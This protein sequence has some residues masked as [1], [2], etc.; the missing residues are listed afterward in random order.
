M[1]AGEA[2]RAKENS[3]GYGFSGA[4]QSTVEGTGPETK[5]LAAALKW[6]RVYCPEQHDLAIWEALDDDSKKTLV[7]LYPHAEGAHNVTLMCKVQRAVNFNKTPP[8]SPI[9]LPIGEGG[10][11]HAGGPGLDGSEGAGMGDGVGAAGFVGA[12]AAIPLRWTTFNLDRGDHA[13]A[14]GARGLLASADAAAEGQQRLGAGA[15]RA[16]DVA[17]IA[18]GPER[19]IIFS[20]KLIDLKQV[21]P[22]RTVASDLTHG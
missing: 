4:S 15:V 21:I 3:R 5:E 18:G 1:Q 17:Q 14:V 19:V 10:G 2:R 12:E 11:E 16:N 13:D 6:D 7:S 22:M 20:L 8:A 9:R